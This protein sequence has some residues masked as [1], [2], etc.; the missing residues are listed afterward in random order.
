MTKPVGTP[1]KVK[2]AVGNP[3]DIQAKSKGIML[4][5]NN[6]V[7]M[8]GNYVLENFMHDE[9]KRNAIKAAYDA[10]P[11]ITLEA[12]TTIDGKADTTKSAPIMLVQHKTGAWDTRKMGRLAIL[13]R[14]S[15]IV[16]HTHYHTSSKVSFSQTALIK[17]LTD[18]CQLAALQNRRKDPIIIPM[19]GLDCVGVLQP[20]GAGSY[21]IN[22]DH[23]KAVTRI[24]AETMFPEADVTLVTPA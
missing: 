21:T 10:A 8:T 15:L 23:V 13:D 17:A 3:F 19:P 18:Y 9:A 22:E 5:S 14:D 1:A 6:T 24:I 7:W 16:I 12:A 4:L 20:T 2:T 11:R